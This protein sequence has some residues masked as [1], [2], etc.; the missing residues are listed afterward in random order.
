VGFDNTNSGLLARNERKQSDTH[1]DF[2]GSINVDGVEYWLSAWV[3]EG[4]EGSKM[5]GKKFFSL[6]VKPK[7]G[8]QPKQKAEPE[9]PPFED[10]IPF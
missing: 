8:Q 4:R 2:T 9:P 3:K 10:E 5:A 1:P 6:S 7:D